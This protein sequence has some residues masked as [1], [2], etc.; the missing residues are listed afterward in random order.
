MIKDNN[1]QIVIFK[2][3]DG[4]TA[5]EVRLEEETVWLNQ[6]Q[7]A[8]LFQRDRTVIS[9]HINNIFTEKELDKKSNVHFLHIANSDRPVAFFSLDV[10]ISVGYRVKSIRGTQFRIW[11]TNVLKQHL[12]QG[13]TINEKRLKEQSDKIVE[14]QKAVNLLSKTAETM[15]LTSD[16]AQGIIKIISDYTHA[17]NILDGYDYDNLKISNTS[18]KEKYKLNFSDAIKF[19]DSLKLKFGT[20][21]L[22]GKI[23]GASFES[24]INTIYQ[25]FGK[26]KLYPSIEEKASNLL[27]F[28]IKNHPFVDGNKRI[29]TSLFIWY[30]AKNNLL[31]K[32]D[33]TKRIAD[34]VLVA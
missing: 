34:N 29:A 24:S 7:M 5:L 9:R 19:V 22:F 2:A 6:F 15:Y 14:L 26:K 12:V 18:G 13:Y 1:K 27:Y 30:L 21:A 8:L 23:R 16:E 4:K 17:L 28:L 20:S 31:Y 11:A 32:P 25:T 3:K 33:G 10:I